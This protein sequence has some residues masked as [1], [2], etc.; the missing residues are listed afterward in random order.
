MFETFTKLHSIS[1]VTDLGLTFKGNVEDTSYMFAGCN[2]ITSI[3]LSS[4]LIPS[5]DE[6]IFDTSNVENMSNMFANCSIIESINLSTPNFGTANVENMS[7]M[8]KNCSNVTQIDLTST[9]FVTTLVT[10]MSSMFEGCSS[11]ERLEL[12][13]FNTAALTNSSR[14]FADCTN[15]EKIYVSTNFVKDGITSSTNMFDGCT[16]PLCGGNGTTYNESNPKDKTYAWIDGRN[17]V[18]GYFWCHDEYTIHYDANAGSDV[19]QNVPDDQTKLYGEN[20]T[21]SDLVPERENYIFKGWVLS[22]SAEIAQYQPSGVFNKNASATLY[23]LWQGNAYHVTLNSQG[24]DVQGSASEHY[25]YNTVRTIGGV[26]TM[27]YSDSAST[28]PLENGAKIVIPQKAG[29]VFGGYY[30]EVNGNGTQYIN[31]NGINVNDLYKT[32]G[33]RTLYA[34]WTQVTY[35][36][37]FNKVDPNATGTMADQTGFVYGVPTPLN[38]NQFANTGYTF[39]GWATT[40]GSMQMVLI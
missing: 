40:S 30:T 16:K 3:D 22:P 7:G 8:F 2:V 26:Q 20:I 11:I 39:K 27:Y 36:V 29:Y 28:I 35:S 6:Y 12:K 19:V 37:R 18:A 1:L 13:Q 4:P 21:L 31:E 15:L 17:D 10:D 14:M 32:L 34:K 24:A 9:K 25:F 23:A 5:S 38:L 33:D